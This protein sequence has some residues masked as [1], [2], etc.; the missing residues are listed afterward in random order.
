MKLKLPKFLLEMSGHVYFHKY[1]M[2]LVYRPDIHRV[3]GK[4]VRKVLEAI[5]SGDMIL[6]RFDQ[7]LNTICTPG[8]WGHASQYVIPVFVHKPRPRIAVCSERQF[9]RV[10]EPLARR[11][12]EAQRVAADF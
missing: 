6:R 8:F 4:D 12:I 9:I 7:Y 10:V 5:M 11:D 1:P 3:R 2:F